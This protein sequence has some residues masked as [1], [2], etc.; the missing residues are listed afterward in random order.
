MSQA[1]RV[2][3]LRAR[4]ARP[5][6]AGD[7]GGFRPPDDPLTSWL[8]Q[9]HAIGR[10]EDWPRSEGEPMAGVLQ[11]DVAALPFAPDSL[12]GIAFFTLFAD[13]D[14]DR[15]TVRSYASLDDLAPAGGPIAPGVHPFPVRWRPVPDDL[16]EWDELVSLAAAEGVGDDL[17]ALGEAW[18][19]AGLGPVAGLKIGGWPSLIQ[20]EVEWV[21]PDGSPVDADFVLQVD[22]DPKTRITWGDGGVLHVG[23]ARTAPDEPPLWL[24]EWQS[25]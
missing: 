8:G 9:V 19:D 6:S 20:G 18:D 7:I 16:P 15:W 24:V 10:E 17:D 11:V 14:R 23:R 12:A 22:T 5:A 3:E 2:H 13:V 21:G 25:L 4:W 1:K